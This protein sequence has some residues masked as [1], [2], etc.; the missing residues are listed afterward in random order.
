M[1][2]I[3]DIEDEIKISGENQ[4]LLFLLNGETYGM[5]TNN[6]IE[7]VEFIP[8]TKVP[9]MPN[10]VMGVTNIR[11]EIIPL[12]DLKMRFGFEK[13]EISKKTSIVVTKVFN[14]VKD[15]IMHIGMIVDEVFEVDDIDKND[16]QESPEFGTKIDSCFIEKMARYKNK[17]IYLLDV[18]YILNYTDLSAN[19]KG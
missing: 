8:F 10:F 18:N 13:I 12:I 9:K 16:V 11:G 15:S 2:N 4:Y 7:I 19:Q 6:V 1:D 3:L 17:Y 5:D 14:R